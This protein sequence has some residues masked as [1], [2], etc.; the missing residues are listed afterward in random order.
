MLPIEIEEALVFGRSALIPVW[1]LR[2]VGLNR[3]QNAQM[4]LASDFNGPRGGCH[5][6]IR[7]IPW[8][9]SL[10]NSVCKRLEIIAAGFEGIRIWGDPHD[11]PATRSGETLTVHLAEVI[12]VRFGIGGQRTED[13]GGVGVHIGQC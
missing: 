3:L 12:A 8:S 2:V 13:R 11:L 6:R 9:R 5:L 10:S 1:I 4:P 7:L